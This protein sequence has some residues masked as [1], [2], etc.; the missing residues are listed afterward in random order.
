MFSRSPL[1]SANCT[2]AKGERLNKIEWVSDTMAPLI[3]VSGPSGCG[4]STIIHRLLNEQYVPLRLSV[5][6]TTRKP[7]PGEQAGVDYHYWSVPEFEKA[8]DAGRFLEWAQVHTN[9]YGTL[10]DDVGPWRAKGVGVVLDI[11]VQGWEQVMRRCPDAVSVFVRTASLATLE[12]RLRGRATESEDAI[13]RRLQTA[14]IE[15]A[16]ADAYDHQIVNDELETAIAEVRTIIASA[17]AAKQ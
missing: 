9:Y 10:E 3:I 4:K 13:Q 6:V 14:Q 7:R 8:K 16:R 2:L 12:T 5:S 1:A 15:L 11:D 17:F